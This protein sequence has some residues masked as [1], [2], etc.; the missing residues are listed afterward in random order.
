MIHSAVTVV[1]PLLRGL[2]Q[3]PVDDGGRHWLPHSGLASLNINCHYTICSSG[4]SVKW[5]SCESESRLKCP[6]NNP[7]IDRFTHQP[8]A[9][10]DL[11]PGAVRAY[12]V[13]EQNEYCS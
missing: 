5:V 13:G 6:E 8:Q 2:K 11:L 1:E 7:A 3:R 4:S 10:L 12:D 9:A